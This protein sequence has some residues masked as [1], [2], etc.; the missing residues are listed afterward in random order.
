MVLYTKKNNLEW[1]AHIPQLKIHERVER[2][3]KYNPRTGVIV[4]AATL[5]TEQ[6]HVLQQQPK[7]LFLPIER[8]DSIIEFPQEGCMISFN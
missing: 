6:M 4:T 3:S 8:W 7:F 1:L 5:Y 2:Y